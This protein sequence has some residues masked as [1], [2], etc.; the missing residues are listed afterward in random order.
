MLKLED[1]SLGHSDLNQI[2]YYDEPAFDLGVMDFYIT[3]S[4][5]DILDHD[6]RS[7][8]A[9]LGGSGDVPLSLFSDLTPLELDMQTGSKYNYYNGLDDDNLIHNLD[10]S[11]NDSDVMMVDPSSVMPVLYSEVRPVKS[12]FGIL[13]NSL[14]SPMSSPD[15][16]NHLT[17]S[18]KSVK[19]SATKTYERST[20]KSVVKDLHMS[21]EDFSSDLINKKKITLHSPTTKVNVKPTIIKNID[22]SQINDSFMSQTIESLNSQP[23]IST[24]TPVRNEIYPKPAYSY[25]CLIALALKNSQY[26]CLPVSEIYSFMCEHFPYFKTAPNGWKNSVRHNLSLNKCFEK[27]EK[28]ATSGS[29]RKGCLWAMNPSKIEKMDEE[30]QKWSKKDPMAILKAMIYPEHLEALERGD[31]KKVGDENFAVD[32]DDEENIEGV[33]SDLEIEPYVEVEADTHSSDDDSPWQFTTLN[34]FAL[35]NFNLT[36]AALAEWPKDDGLTT[37]LVQKTRLVK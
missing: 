37:R 6:V 12:R 11:G 25:S 4:L 30:V 9:L 16:K 7:D 17:F 19:I 26:G 24:S 27:I 2:K 32:Y 18:P 15:A 28:P 1:I 31:M 14:D 3:D 36:E 23:R 35:K 10:L 8:F 22:K 34:D 5:H 33:D 29:Q 21:Q 20:S 13:N